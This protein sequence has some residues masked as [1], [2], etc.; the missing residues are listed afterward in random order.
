MQTHYFKMKF[1]LITLVIKLL[2]KSNVSNLLNAP[3]R[4]LGSLDIQF[5]YNNSFEYKKYTSSICLD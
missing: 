4:S 1:K 3:E 5:P 2:D